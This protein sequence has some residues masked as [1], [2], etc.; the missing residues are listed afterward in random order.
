LFAQT[1]QNDAI[2]FSSSGPFGSFM[3]EFRGKTA[4]TF[5]VAYDFESNW[6]Y[7]D[8]SPYAAVPGDVKPNDTRGSSRQEPSFFSD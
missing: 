4:A 5:I 3:I 2:T 6:F 8:P 7:I 1:T